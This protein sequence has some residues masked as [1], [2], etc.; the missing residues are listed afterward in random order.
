MVFNELLEFFG[1]ER[2]VE[3][4][5]ED[6]QGVSLRNLPLV[7]LHFLRRSHLLVVFLAFVVR[8]GRSSVLN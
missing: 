3:A 1:G 7:H 8:Q 2:F 6:C 4:I 5:F